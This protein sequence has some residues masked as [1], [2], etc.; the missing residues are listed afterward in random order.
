[1]TLLR[2]QSQASAVASLW[3]DETKGG[4]DVAKPAD[5]PWSD[6]LDAL[7]AAPKHHWLVFENDRVRVLDTRIAP[8][9]P[10]TRVRF[11]SA[12]HIG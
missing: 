2:P 6:E 9:S 10:I 7:M 8:G 4:G 11:H 12:M 3:R 5:W 1:M